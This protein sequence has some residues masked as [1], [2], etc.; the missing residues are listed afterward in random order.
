MSLS[1]PTATTS[2]A[3]LYLKWKGITGVLY[4]YNKESDKEVEI[5]R[6]FKF[7]VL[8]ELHSVSGFSEQD[9]SGIYSNEVRVI[10][11]ELHIMTR[12]GE[13]L[14]G[15]YTQI[16][17]SIK[18]KGGKYTKSIYLATEIDGETIIANLKLSGAA[19]GAWMDFTRENKGYTDTEVTIEEKALEGKKGATVFQ[20]PI[21]KVSEMSYEVRDTATE[22]DKELQTYLDQKLG[23]KAEADRPMKQSDVF[24]SLD[25]EPNDVPEG[26]IDLSSI[27]F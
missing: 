14:R 7:V 1:R 16:K 10:G 23:E 19:G 11:E 13:L 3:K 15:P 2:P 6:P 18:A 27:P 21:F 25:I 5:E 20:M 17:D 26:E 12:A 4:Y 24:K 8:D 22:L 9:N